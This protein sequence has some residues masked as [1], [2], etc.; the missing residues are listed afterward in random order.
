MSDNFILSLVWDPISRKLVFTKNMECA[1]M[2]SY[3]IL[4]I[5]VLIWNSELSQL[6]E[7]LL[8]L[9]LI[10]QAPWT[11]R[12]SSNCKKI[13]P[14]EIRPHSVTITE[15]GA[16][17]DGVTSNTKAFQNAIF[18]LQSFAD[19]GGAQLF[20]PAGRWLTGSIELISHLTLLLDKKAVILGSQV[21]QYYYL[22]GLSINA[23]HL[24][25][26]SYAL[27]IIITLFASMPC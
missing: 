5:P 1:S 20:V 11:V 23:L 3:L 6:V 13:S 12:G 19:K 16:V 8:V 25:Y 27:L 14:L 10:S 4:G 24:F 21:S 9:T 17:G 22:L 26:P 2:I 7:V 15:F 18:Y